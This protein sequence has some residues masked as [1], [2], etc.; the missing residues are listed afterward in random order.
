[1]S[2]Q[3][4]GGKGVATQGCYDQ[5]AAMGGR[6]SE[7]KTRMSKLSALPTRKPGER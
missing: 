7:A 1:M 3:D 2:Q 4:G 6:K 5:G